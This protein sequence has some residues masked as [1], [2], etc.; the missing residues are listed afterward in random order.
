VSSFQSTKSAQ[1]SVVYMA[2]IGFCSRQVKAVIMTVFSKINDDFSD[3]MFDKM[4]C[5]KLFTN[6]CNF[7]QNNQVAFNHVLKLVTS[8][9]IL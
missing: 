2:S 6:I 3:I 5:P 9:L 1:S 4:R 8:S 7:V